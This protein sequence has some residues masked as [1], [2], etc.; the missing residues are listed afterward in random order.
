MTGNNL[1]VHIMEP[2]T[3]W[4]FKVRQLAQKNTHG[5]PLFKIKEM[6]ERYEK[7]INLES[8][9]LEWNLPELKEHEHDC[10][11][12]DVEITEEKSSAFKMNEITEE[13]NAIEN[14]IPTTDGGGENC[15]EM[16]TGALKG[17]IQE[18]NSTGNDH[19]P[20]LEQ[21]LQDPQL[22][23][24]E[25]IKIVDYPESSDEEELFM[26][27]SDSEVRE[28]DTAL[29]PC[30]PEFVP[31]A[32]RENSP[33]ALPCVLGEEGVQ[34]DGEGM[35]QDWQGVGGLLGSLREAAGMVY[36]DKVVPILLCG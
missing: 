2:N 14:R 35:S 21:E 19:L 17:V 36:A 26:S 24:G 4:K 6:M 28:P 12:D 18:G 20:K 13:V 25:D 7:N 16:N 31:L 3:S 10:R 9:L 8:L 1:Q 23:K 34:E 32:S 22:Q 5:V 29:N 15:N 33:V 11:P 27:D 30:V